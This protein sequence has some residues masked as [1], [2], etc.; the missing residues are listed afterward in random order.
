MFDLHKVFSTE[1]ERAWAI[2]GCTTA[3]I[4]CIDCKV[5][6]IAHIIEIMEPIWER[7]QHLMAN[8]DILNDA[9][10]RGVAKATEVCEAT[11]QDVRKHMGF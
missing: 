1:D 10:D 5:V 3:G 8:P 7:R 4:G 9:V 11:M 6:L 2:E